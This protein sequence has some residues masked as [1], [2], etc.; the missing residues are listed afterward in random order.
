MELS[1]IT[2]SVLSSLM[3][4]A[5]VD[6]TSTVLWTSNNPLADLAS[7]RQLVDKGEWLWVRRSQ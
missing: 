5:I 4:N 7:G 2:S 6:G 3:N 1:F